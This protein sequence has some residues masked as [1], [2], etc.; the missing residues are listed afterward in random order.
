MGV[1]TVLEK[2]KERGLQSDLDASVCL[3]CGR[4]CVVDVVDVVVC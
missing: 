1:G 3:V 2:E 4:V